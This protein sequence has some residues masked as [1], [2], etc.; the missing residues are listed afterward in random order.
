MGLRVM[1]ATQRG[2]YNTVGKGSVNKAERCWMKNEE[3]TPTLSTS[4]QGASRCVI[5]DPGKGKGETRPPLDCGPE[6]LL[7]WNQATP[8]WSLHSEALP[9][10]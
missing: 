10:T 4:M 6:L 7:P 2:G 5:L 8:P 9:G 1:P 3:A